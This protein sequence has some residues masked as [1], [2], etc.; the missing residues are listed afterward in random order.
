MLRKLMLSMPPEY[1][2]RSVGHLLLLA[3]PAVELE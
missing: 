3:A 2:V 1:L